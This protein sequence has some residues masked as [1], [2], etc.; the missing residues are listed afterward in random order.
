MWLVFVD[1]TKQKGLRSGMGSLLSLG[2]VAFPE[3]QVARYAD[4]AAEIYREHNAPAD[5]ELKWSP[6]KGSWFKSDAGAAC[7]TDLRQELLAAAKDCDCRAV[8]VA[9]DLGRTSI[10]GTRAEQD[11]LKYLFERIVM[12]LGDDRG[13][14]ICDKPGGGHKAEDNW[15][16][17]TLDLTNFGTNYVKADAVVLPILT[18]PSHHHPHLQLADLVAGSMTAAVAGIRF[19]LELVPH[20]KPLLH[21]NTSG[22]IAGTGLK[23][24][25]DT[26]VNVYHW[27][28]GA[29][30]YMRGSSGYA[31]PRA[32]QPYEK[33]DGMSLVGN[34]RS[35]LA[36]KKFGSDS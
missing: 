8:V 18:A 27:V 14:V 3:E 12:M 6:R 4:R 36:G 34:L 1:D 7:L 5:A 30:S 25:P 9:F 26:I 15:I 2:A 31:L 24:F 19:G 23:L 13:V 28:L 17:G 35:H 32:F 11:V 22:A 21:T 29:D 20:V 33:D 10:Q 16:A